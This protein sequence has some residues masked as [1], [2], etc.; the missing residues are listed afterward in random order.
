MIELILK[1]SADQVDQV[2]ALSLGLGH[3]LGCIWP[4]KGITKGC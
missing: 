3:T 4:Q 1:T 2:N